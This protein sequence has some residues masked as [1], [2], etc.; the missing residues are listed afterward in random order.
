MTVT[1]TANRYGGFSAFLP[2]QTFRGERIWEIM[3]TPR[4][5]YCDRGRWEANVW[6]G[7]VSPLDMQEGFPRY[8]FDLVRAQAELEAWATG[9]IELNQDRGVAEV[10]GGE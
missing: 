2:A 1:W 10:H 3:L 9:R 8:Y 6:D 4:P 5:G 7:T